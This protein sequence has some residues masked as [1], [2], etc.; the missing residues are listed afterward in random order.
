MK[1][2]CHC[3]IWSISR[4][5]WII[6]STYIYIFS[7]LK[8]KSLYMTW[9]YRVCILY[10][11]KEIYW[12]CTTIHDNNFSLYRFVFQLEYR[13]H[14]LCYMKNMSEYDEN[15]FNIKIINI[16]KYEYGMYQNK[17]NFYWKKKMIVC[18]LFLIIFSNK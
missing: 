6:V 14:F 13:I 2:K 16:I 5:W 1:W 12:I 9:L 4:L 11:Y 10:M 3:W 15:C 18:C 7:N 8:S 17:L